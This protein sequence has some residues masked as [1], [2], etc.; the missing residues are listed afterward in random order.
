MIRF[1]V[2]LLL[3][4]LTATGGE[5]PISLILE[6]D[7]LHI[8]GDLTGA[9]DK[10]QQ[11]LNSD[12]TN[13]FG[14]NLLGLV[15]LKLDQSQ[16]AAEQFSY[17][18]VLDPAG[19]TGTAYR[20]MDFDMSVG[21]IVPHGLADEDM[22]IILRNVDRAR[23]LIK[24]DEKDAIVVRWFEATTSEERMVFAGELQELNNRYP[25]YIILWYPKGMWA[26]RKDVYDNY[27]VSP[28]YGIFHKWSFLPDEARKHTTMK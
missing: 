14:R 20:T 5:Q 19:F 23:E 12:P 26:Y 16:E 10:L 2:F 11:A 21:E 6:A 8:S 18:Q 15:F 22:L 4:V 3:Y 1:A 17:V 25:N 28:G 7:L 24:D 13:I 9:R 27:V